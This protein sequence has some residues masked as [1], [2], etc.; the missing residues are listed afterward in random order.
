MT[1]TLIT[2]EDLKDLSTA[3]LKSK[4]FRM[5]EDVERMRETCAALPLAEQSL[6]NVSR[7]LAAR[8]ARGPRP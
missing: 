6:A 1:S 8:K 7:A 5:R 2:S 3:E 4:F